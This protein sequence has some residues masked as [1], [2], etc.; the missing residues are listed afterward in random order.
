MYNYTLI[1][2]SFE[3]CTLVEYVFEAFDTV[4]LNVNSFEV[5]NGNK[6]KV[7][8]E[9]IEYYV[10]AS[11]DD[12][13]ETLKFELLDGSD[14]LVEVLTLGDFDDSNSVSSILSNYYKKDNLSYF[15]DV[16]TAKPTQILDVVDE[17]TDRK[18]SWRTT[19]AVSNVEPESIVPDSI[20]ECRVV[21]LVYNNSTIAY[22]FKTNVGSFDMSRDVASQYGLAPDKVTKFTRLLL[23][24]DIFMT[25]GEYDAGRLIP[26]I[27][28]SKVDC[29]RLFSALFKGVGL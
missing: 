3:N 21:A 26:D 2:P 16:P 25:K 1:E 14:K 7:T 5:I 27:S 22:R 11:T 19:G 23:V 15:E 17:E 18:T 6:F 10:F 4:G 29:D 8:F 13:F 24:N 20:Y 28:G 9:E 12:S